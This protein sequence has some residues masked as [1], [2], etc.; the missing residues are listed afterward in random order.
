MKQYIENKFTKQYKATVGAD[1]LTKKIRLDCGQEVT[2]QVLLLLLS[3]TIIQ[4]VFKIINTRFGIQLVK[5]D[6]KV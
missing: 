1:F 5:R 6:L 3:I 2:L 4:K